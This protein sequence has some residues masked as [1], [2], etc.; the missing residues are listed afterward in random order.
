VDGS[1]LNG[2][3]TVSGGVRPQGVQ[4]SGIA[5]LNDTLEGPWPPLPIRLWKRGEV[6]SDVVTGVKWV[7]VEGGVRGG[8]VSCGS[9]EM[10]GGVF[11]G[12]EG[13]GLVRG[14]VSSD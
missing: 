2:R 8:E 10:G 14:E 5:E 1:P 6:G 11:A 7:E 4:G 13:A 12:W 3:K 9:K